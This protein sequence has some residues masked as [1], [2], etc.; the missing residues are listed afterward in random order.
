MHVYVCGVFSVLLFRVVVVHALAWGTLPWSSAPSC[1]LS[2]SL[3]FFLSFFLV[4]FSNRSHAFSFVP[5][6]EQYGIILLE[7]VPI[8]N[9]EKR[10]AMRRFITL[11]DVLYDASV[12]FIVSAAAEP[13]QLYPIGVTN[14]NASVA[15]GMHVMVWGG[16]RGTEGERKRAISTYVDW[17]AIA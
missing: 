9:N 5:V 6:A 4:F 16:G 3:S 2:F 1:F 12:R 10:A 8:F 7:D 11:L 17:G 14:S 13:H 15:Q